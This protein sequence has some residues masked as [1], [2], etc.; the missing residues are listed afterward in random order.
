MPFKTGQQALD[1]LI[2]NSGGVKH[3]KLI[4]WWRTS[5][6]FWCGQGF[7]G[8]R[9]PKGKDTGKVFNLPLPPIPFA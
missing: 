7:C 8:V 4:F 2:E 6:Q 1:F 5:A 9:A 3:R